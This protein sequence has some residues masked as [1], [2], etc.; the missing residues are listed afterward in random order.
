MALPSSE[1]LYQEEHITDNAVTS[2][3]VSNVVCFV[4]AFV[5]IT[6]KLISQRLRHLSLQVDDY[7]AMAATVGM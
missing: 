3:I 4:I 2:L 5:A 1:I 6:L 7:L